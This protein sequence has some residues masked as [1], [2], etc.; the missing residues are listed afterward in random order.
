MS[1][2]DYVIKFEQL[3]NEAKNYQMEIH[4][5]VL[6]YRLLNNANLSEADKQL[7]KATITK[8]EYNNMKEQLKRVFTNTDS[9]SL[10][11]IIRNNNIEKQVEFKTEPVDTYFSEEDP[12]D[13]FYGRGNYNAPR[14]R[15][16]RFSNRG[17]GG[18]RGSGAARGFRKMNPLDQHGRISR[19]NIC[20]SKL[21]WSRSCPD[22]HENRN[23]EQ[24]QEKRNKPPMA[25][26]YM[27]L[28]I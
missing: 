9:K 28:V 3:Y 26:D 10:P 21:H 23:Y 17:R 11:G 5:G 14:Y 20:D 19:C 8:M 22:A 12:H 1:I 24:Q 27:S 6:S 15:V 13:T 4:D 25:V 2:V 16:G 18:N 7:I